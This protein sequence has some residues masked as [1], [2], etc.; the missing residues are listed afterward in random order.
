MAKLTS[1]RQKTSQANA[2]LRQQ[3]V[4]NSLDVQTSLCVCTVYKLHV[5][6]SFSPRR[7]LCQTLSEQQKLYCPTFG[8]ASLSSDVWKSGNIVA[9]LKELESYD[10][11]WSFACVGKLDFKCLAYDK[12]SKSKIVDLLTLKVFRQ[13]LFC[14]FKP[15]NTT[16]AIYRTKRSKLSYH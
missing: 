3:R 16:H 10:I 2:K 7:W 5:H 13:Q 14:I 12:E 1:K 15:C 8:F 6:P 4:P 9:E 11:A